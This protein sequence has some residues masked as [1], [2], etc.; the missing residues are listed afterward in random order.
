[1]ENRLRDHLLQFS[2]RHEV[3]LTQLHI[4]KAA[5]VP[6][7]NEFHPLPFLERVV[8][9]CSGH[10]EIPSERL[11]YDLQPKY[12]C[13]QVSCSHSTPGKPKVSVAVGKGTLGLSEAEK[14]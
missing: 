3:S 6:H 4:H 7:Q 13:S 14:C 8:S 1:M 10:G 5:C 9:Q 12:L 11:E 2:T